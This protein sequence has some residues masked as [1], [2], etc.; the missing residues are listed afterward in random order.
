MNTEY[1]QFVATLL[2]AAGEVKLYQAGRGAEYRPLYGSGHD[3]YGRA[4]KRLQTPR[5]R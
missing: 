2:K 4:F 1:T 5:G 3:L